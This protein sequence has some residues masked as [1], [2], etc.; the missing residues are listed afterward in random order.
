MNESATPGPTRFI[1]C[2]IGKD[3]IVVH[4]SAEG[5]TCTLP[6][7]AA[8]LA[9]LAATLDRH[10]LIVCEATG[11]YEATLL[12]AAVAAAIPAHRAD[13]RRVKA[14]IRSHGT[15]GKTDALDAMALARYGA[16][17]H[18]TL[19]RWRPRDDARE[20]LR[21]LV[22]TRTELVHDRTACKNRLA[23]PGAALVEVRLRRILDALDAEIT[24]LDI[25]IE[26]LI[27]TT[28]PLATA[29]ATLR[30]IKGLGATTAAALL[31]L[32]PELGTL[33]RR[34][35]AALA[36]LAPHPRQSGPT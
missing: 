29:T 2:D 12:D 10:C 23:A 22:H 19:A 34:Q 4:D 28:P 26:Q 20:Q 13:T 21:R 1:G 9:R 36:G 16:E 24:G 8:A 7:E 33:G 31:A 15:L 27:R 32:M 11:G 6:N 5:A 17:R 35:I 18:A 3:G 30:S 14:F 25:D